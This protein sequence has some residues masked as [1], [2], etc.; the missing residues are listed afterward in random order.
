MAISVKPRGSARRVEI[1][2]GLTT[3][4][5]GVDPLEMHGT[6]E[7][8]QITGGITGLGGGFGHI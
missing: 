2:G 1:A 3:H 6:I 7:A 5:P 8:L 4:G